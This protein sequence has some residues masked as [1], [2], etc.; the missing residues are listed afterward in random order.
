MRFF[1]PEL[2][3]DWEAISKYKKLEFTFEY[4]KR[5]N[6]EETFDIKFQSST[7]RFTIKIKTK[8]FD[9]FAGMLRDICIDNKIDAEVIRE[10]IIKAEAT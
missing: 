4:I 6:M 3:A 10:D 5:R 2:Q 9:K 8:D 1:D 7:E